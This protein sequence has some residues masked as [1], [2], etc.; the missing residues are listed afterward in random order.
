MES[1]NSN[2]KRN[3]SAHLLIG[4]VLVLLG[5][6]FLAEMFDAVPWR[7]KNIIF[8]WQMILIVLGIIFI[9]GRDGKSTGYILLAIGI[10][11]ILP[12]FTN[13]PDYWR[14]LFWPSLLIL[15]GIF[16]IFNRGKRPRHHKQHESSSSDDFIDEVCIFGGSEK[17]LYS[18]NFRGGKITHVF[19]GTNYDFRQVRLAEGT[20]YL[21]ISMIF[22][23]T[24][25]V[26]P[27]DWDVKIEITSIFGGFADKRRRTIVVP[28]SNRKLVIRGENIFGGGEI[29]YI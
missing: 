1:N 13:V 11:F 8:S 16:I 21:N 14:S 20:N 29:T 17:V 18:Q 7:M 24:K 23:G 3:K 28:D 10:F 5:I 19:G 22:G 4:I 26:V 12:K 15:G 27:E 25:F 9:S 6:A 2:F